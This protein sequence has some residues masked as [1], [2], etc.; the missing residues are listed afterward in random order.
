MKRAIG[1]SYFALGMAEEGEKAFE[2]LVREFPDNPWSYMGWAAPI[3]VRVR[4]RRP[5]MTRRSGSTAWHWGE[6]FIF[7]LDVVEKR[8]SAQ[9]W[10]RS[11]AISV[12]KLTYLRHPEQFAGPL[13]VCSQL[14][15]RLLIS[16]VDPS[17][18]LVFGCG[19][20]CHQNDF[21]ETSEWP[22]LLYCGIHSP[23]LASPFLYILR[24]P[25]E[26]EI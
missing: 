7:D 10:G 12:K 4:A 13:R 15:T 17:I 8:P 6:I 23:P 9:G 3:S 25:A 16:Q 22:L 19:G 5:T 20:T 14:L 1:E 18:P 2:A 11:A 24:Y 26:S 21:E